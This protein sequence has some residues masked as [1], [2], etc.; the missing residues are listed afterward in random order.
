MKYAAYLEFFLP[1]RLTIVTIAMN[2]VFLLES[3]L[4]RRDHLYTGNIMLPVAAVVN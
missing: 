3:N 1:M 4:Q 2:R